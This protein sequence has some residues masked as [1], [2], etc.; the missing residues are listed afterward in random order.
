MEIVECKN[1]IM[2]YLDLCRT[3]GPNESKD[4][5]IIVA[6]DQ[7]VVRQMFQAFFDE[8]VLSDRILFCK[9]GQ[10]VVELVKGFLKQLTT[11]DP[12]LDTQTKVRPVSLILMDINMPFKSGLEAKK[13]VCEL[14]ENS[15]KAWSEQTKEDEA[16]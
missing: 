6:D 3:D 9:N 12:T 11:S 13:E 7:F 5:L 14:Y 16:S 15:N 8:I 4:G 10:E 1:N 2:S